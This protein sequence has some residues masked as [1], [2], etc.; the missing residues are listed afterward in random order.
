MDTERRIVDMYS[1]M[2]GKDTKIQSIAKSDIKKAK[3]VNP[4]KLGRKR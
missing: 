2:F 4:R 3:K 1:R